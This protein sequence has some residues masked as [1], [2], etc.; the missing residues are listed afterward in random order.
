MSDRIRS[1]INSDRM[2]D[3]IKYIITGSFCYFAIEG[4]K[5]IVWV[6]EDNNAQLICVP[7]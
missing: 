1:G 3:K 4:K 7:K 2:I 6:G 5:S